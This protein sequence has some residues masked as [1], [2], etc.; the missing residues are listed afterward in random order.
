ML[1]TFALAR[2]SE[3]TLLLYSSGGI[4]DVEFE[5]MK[6]FIV[7]HQSFEHNL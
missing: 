6:C 7:D 4:F 3:T 2:S 5:F 1:R